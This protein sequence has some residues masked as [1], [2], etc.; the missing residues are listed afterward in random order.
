M[1]WNRKL[2]GV[3][4]LSRI[5]PLPDFLKWQTVIFV[6]RH[7]HYLVSSFIVNNYVKFIWAVGERLPSSLLQTACTLRW[8]KVNG[9]RLPRVELSIMCLVGIEDRRFGHAFRIVGPNEFFLTSHHV[10]PMRGCWSCRD[11]PI[12]PCP[13]PFSSFFWQCRST[14]TMATSSSY[15]QPL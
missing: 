15:P 11:L 3:V 4:N 9:L 7:S 5:M 10:F 1:H 2:M 14:S 6:L 8:M 12:S 13:I